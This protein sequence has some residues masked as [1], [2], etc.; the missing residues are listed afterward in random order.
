MR[1]LGGLS[2]RCIA[3][4]A[5]EDS[6][7]H[8]V[9]VWMMKT[10]NPLPREGDSPARPLYAGLG[11]LILMLCSVSYSRYTFQAHK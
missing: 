11:G 6:L 4:P 9:G 3:T 7:L 5:T 10:N 1:L 8:R 2:P